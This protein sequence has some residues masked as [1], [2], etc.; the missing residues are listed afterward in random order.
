[1]RKLGK[2]SSKRP[3]TPAHEPTHIAAAFDAGTPI[4]DALAAGVREA[5]ER[6]RR[7]GQSIVVWRDGRVT[8]VPAEEIPT[9]AAASAPPARKPRRRRAG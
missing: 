2:R 9:I 1:M 3:Q 8:W 5:L 7:L 4:D 6:H